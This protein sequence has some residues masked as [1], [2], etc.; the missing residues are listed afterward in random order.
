MLRGNQ[1]LDAALAG[2]VEMPR[3]ATFLPWHKYMFVNGEVGN[4]G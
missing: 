2:R 4:K 1:L 3:G